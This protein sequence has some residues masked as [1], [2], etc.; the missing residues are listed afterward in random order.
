MR[1][2]KDYDIV[3]TPAKP[4]VK[5]YIF[6]TQTDETTNIFSNIEHGTSL[7]FVRGRLLGHTDNDL[8][9]IRV[10]DFLSSIEE[11]NIRIYF[12]Q[13]ILRRYNKRLVYWELSNVPERFRSGFDIK[14]L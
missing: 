7:K 5:A 2:W 13:F 6:G 1:Y 9:N 11:K 4:R 8:A 12:K 10:D 14:S 3:I